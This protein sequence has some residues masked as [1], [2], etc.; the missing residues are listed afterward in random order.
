MGRRAVGVASVVALVAWVGAALS[1]VL[2]AALGVV[3]LSGWGDYHYRVDV[4]L[5]GISLHAGYQPS[6]GVTGG[7]EVCRTVDVNRPSADCL[8]FVLQRADQQQ[9]GP[10]LEQGPV[11]P[12]RAVLGGR[13][14]LDAAPGWNSLVASLYAMQVLSLLV[15]AFLLAQLWL[16]LRSAARG[17]WF[18]G[19]M[20]RRVRVLGWTIVAWEVVEPFLWLF[21]SPKAHDYGETLVGPGPDLTLGSMQ[22]GGPSLTVIAFGLLIALLAEL[23]R[24]GAELADEQRLTV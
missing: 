3:G 24:L 8:G 12:V 16:M 6:W 20:V 2:V 19:A 15:L 18:A 22:P 4:P 9:S 11:R 5:P 21:L 7:E 23:F 1:A 14:L 10:V 17:E 13:M